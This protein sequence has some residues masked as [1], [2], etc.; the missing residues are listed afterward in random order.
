MKQ[1][2]IAIAA[3]FT[4]AL[5]FAQYEGYN[6][7]SVELNGGLS[8]FNQMWLG[9]G[10]IYPAGYTTA[11]IATS[12]SFQGIEVQN[13]GFSLNPLHVNL[14]VRKMITPSLGFRLGVSYDN[15]KNENNTQ[16]QFNAKYIGANGQVY[17]NL[18]KLTGADLLWNRLNIL[19]HFGGGWALF[20]VDDKYSVSEYSKNNKDNLFSLMMGLTAQFRIIDRLALTADITNNWYG[21]AHMELDGSRV[22]SNKGYIDAA[23]LNVSAGLTFY[24]GKQKKHID[25][26]QKPVIEDKEAEEAKDYAPAIEELQNKIK[27]LEAR[28]VAAAGDVNSLQNRIKDLENQIKNLNT[29]TKDMMDAN[30][31]HAYF[32]FDQDE[33]KPSSQRDIQTAIDYMK[34]NANAKMELVGYADKIGTAAYNEDLSKRRVENIK[35]K[36]I[37]AGIAESRLSLSWRGSKDTPQNSADERALARKVVFRVQ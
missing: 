15:L 37:K 9:T 17:V 24:L 16:A 11:G 19:G 4:G 21:S 32:D 6:T 22:E 13:D 20:D 5:G 8:S 1:K 18:N 29:S 25:W 30:I 7:W 27:A 26:Y 35:N 31:I 36:M 34:N 3:L 2:F 12:G 14:G 28:P 23:V 10:D 33:P